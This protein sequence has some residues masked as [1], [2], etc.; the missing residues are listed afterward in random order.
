MHIKVTLLPD[1][2]HAHSAGCLLAK[3]SGQPRLDNNKDGC[4][5]SAY[6][7]VCAKDR[8]LKTLRI[9]MANTSVAAS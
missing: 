9:W 8:H 4:V 1:G 2:S 6:G 5:C 3:P 7:T